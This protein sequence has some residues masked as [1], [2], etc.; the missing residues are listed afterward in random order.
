M[1]SN[2]RMIRR[3]PPHQLHNL[4]IGNRRHIGN[5]GKPDSLCSRG[6]RRIRAMPAARGCRR[7]PCRRDGRWLG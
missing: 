5:Y 4:H 1:R 7:F 2:P 6:S 3:I